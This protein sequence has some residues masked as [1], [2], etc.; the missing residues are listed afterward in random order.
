MNVVLVPLDGEFPLSSG[1]DVCVECSVESASPRRV[2]ARQARARSGEGE[3]GRA[4]ER[5]RER[6]N[7]REAERVREDLLPSLMTR[8]EGITED[9]A[10]GF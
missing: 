4:C 8:F 1:G 3:R 9:G 7:E 6:E 5:E 10:H 2:Q